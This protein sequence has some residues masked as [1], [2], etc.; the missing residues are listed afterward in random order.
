V[1]DRELRFDRK[2][3]DAEA[4]MWNIEHD[5]RLSS[6]IASIIV[7]DRELDFD[8]IRRRINNAVAEIPR[9]RERVSHVLGRL[10]PPMWVPDAE[11][12]LDFHVRRVALPAPG[13]DRDL[14]DLCT[15]LL[16]EPFDRTRPSDRPSIA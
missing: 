7:C 5:P 14:Y 1:S 4:M 2:M 12:D 11:F 16:Q 9:M 10:S 6:N 3:S 8:K 13:S 15:R